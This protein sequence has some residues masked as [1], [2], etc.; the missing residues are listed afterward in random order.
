MT[1]F[2]TVKEKPE[3]CEECVFNCVNSHLG[4]PLKELP[5]KLPEIENAS[6]SYN[7]R[8]EAWNVLIDFFI[9]NAE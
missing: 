3:S 2:V 9:E 1:Y 4:C 8:R 5:P 6:D 7:A